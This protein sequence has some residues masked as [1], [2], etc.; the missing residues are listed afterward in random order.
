MNKCPRC[1]KIDKTVLLDND[2]EPYLCD[3]CWE[4]DNVQD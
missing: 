1:L 4:D 2:N 3:D